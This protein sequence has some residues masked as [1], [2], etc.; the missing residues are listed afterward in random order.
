MICQA[1]DFQGPG[2]PHSSRL[3]FPSGLS[4]VK[5]S[6]PKRLASL[7]LRAALER[8]FWMLAPHVFPILQ[9]LTLK[10]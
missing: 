5:L 1:L 7:K 3:Q 6:L 8:K 4:G 2:N 9:I 10:G